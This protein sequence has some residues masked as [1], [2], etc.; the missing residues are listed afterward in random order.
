MCDRAGFGGWEKNC[1]G[2]I[3]KG[4]FSPAASDEKT[5]DYRTKSSY[6]T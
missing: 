6:S 2:S 5:S 4:R 1:S 3:N